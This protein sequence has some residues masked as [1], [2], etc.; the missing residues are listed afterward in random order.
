[1]SLLRAI[2]RTCAVGAVRPLFLYPV[3]APYSRA[4]TTEMVGRQTQIA[5]SKKAPRT[6]EQ[7]TSLRQIDRQI[8]AKAF[9]TG[10]LKGSTRLR[11]VAEAQH[12]SA[13]SR[14]RLS[15]SCLHFA[16][17]YVYTSCLL[18]QEIP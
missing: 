10:S 1:M 6:P 12:W 15:L 9:V 11:M 3:I 18:N 8:H 2:I 5:P 13:S 14:W 7:M 17:R 4:L 16:P